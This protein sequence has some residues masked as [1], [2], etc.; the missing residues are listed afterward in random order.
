MNNTVSKI[1]YNHLSKNLSTAYIYSG[2][3]IMTLINHFSENK[4]KYYIPSSEMSAGFCSIG[5]NKLLNRCD[6][7]II[8]TSGPGLT[9]TITPITD[10]FCDRVPLLV[11]SGDVSTNM[12]GKD[13]FQEAPSIKLTSPIT[14]WNYTLT[15]ENEIH[16]VMNTTFNLLKNGKQVHLNIPKDIINKTVLYNKNIKN[17]IKIDLQYNYSLSLIKEIGDIINNSNN[18]IFYIGK[19]CRYASEV[20]KK[21]ALKANIPVTTTLHGLGIF[22]EESYLS[23]KMVGMHGSEKANNSIQLSDCII[24]VGA[25]FDD[26]TVGNIDK[27]APNAKHIIHINNDKTTFNKV[28]NNTINVYGESFDILSKLENYIIEKKNSE[29]IQYLDKYTKNFYFN[30]NIL[31]QQYILTILNKLFNKENTIIVTGVGNHQM[32]SAQYI[33]YRYP[34]RF[35]TSGSLGTMGSCNSLSIGAKI[36]NPNKIII[37]IDGDNSF[38]MLNDLKMIMNYNIPIKMIIMNDGKQS[39]V[40]V[41]EKLFFDG[42]IV[43]T[44]SINP[45]YEFIAKAYNIKYI[46]INKKDDVYD[47]I[48]EFINYDFN[49]SV[50]LDCHVKS[51]Y[52]LP[53]VPPGAAL[54]EMITYK[55]INDYKPTTDI[56]P[57]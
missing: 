6:S 42:N 49:K 41:W 22:D 30:N 2:G 14:Y 50:I 5:H 48:K 39:M 9:N 27:Y 35:I 45:N 24:C 29:W 46:Q 53:L 11:I 4:M 1:I 33:E 51:D 3:S 52:C 7:V 25:R 31:N 54:N 55:N 57:N 21:I 16:D 15:D 37:A 32:Y 23:L 12:M 10:A 8:T 17:D 38:N 44:E 13:A 26:R 20:L 40:N 19:G 36:A 34:N 47:K 56:A 18:P 43:A 28:L